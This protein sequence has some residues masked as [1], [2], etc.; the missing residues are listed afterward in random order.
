MSN[1]EHSEILEASSFVVIAAECDGAAARIAHPGKLRDVL[2]YVTCLCRRPWRECQTDGIAELIERVDDP[3]NWMTSQSE[4]F[5]I[6]WD[7]EDG[8]V[9]V[10]RLDRRRRDDD[11]AAA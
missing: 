10:Y 1:E 6:S 7:Q 4:P 5:S 8:H 11:Y 3:D 9:Y 2:H